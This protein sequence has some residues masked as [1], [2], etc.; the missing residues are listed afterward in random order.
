MIVDG[1]ISVAE[2]R[3]ALEALGATVALPDNVQPGGKI[4]LEV[5]VNDEDAARALPSTWFTPDEEEVDDRADPRDVAD[6]VDACRAGDR[7][8]ARALAG[9]LF[10]SDSNM[11]AVELS[12]GGAA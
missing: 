11:L 8:M 7:M 2:L 12:F 4:T 3:T 10:V 9:R 5:T 1:T 6:F